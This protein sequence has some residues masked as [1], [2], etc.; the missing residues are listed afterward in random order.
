MKTTKLILNVLLIV[1]IA[2]FSLVGC[3]QL[4]L[5]SIDTPSDLQDRIDSIAAEKSKVD[6]GD[7]TYIDIARLLV[8]EDDNSAGWWTEFTDYFSVPVNKLL[9]LE[10]INHSSGENNWNNWNLVISNDAESRESDDYK[11]Y[12]VLRSDAFGWGGAMA[13]DGYEYDGGIISH[14][15]VEVLGED[16]M[17]D[18]FRETMQGAYVTMEVDH[19]STGNVFVTATAV[20]TNGLTIVQEYNQ[21]VSVSADITAFMVCDGSHFEMKSAYLIPSKVSIIED[22]EPVSIT[23]E[24]APTAIEL[25]NEDFWGNAIATVTFADGSSA[26]VDT[27]DLTFAVIPDLT[28]VG[29]KSVVVSY[30]KTK[31]GNYTQAV[32][33][34]YK[35]EVTNLVVGISA[36]NIN[37]YYSSGDDIHFDPRGII[38]TANYA[39]GSTAILDSKNVVLSYPALVSP[40]VGEQVVEVS[41]EG[42]SE[43]YTTTSTVTLVQGLSQV[44]LNDM[45]T[46]WWS[47]FS[48]DYSVPAGTSKTISMYCY[49][50]ELNGWHSPCTILRGE[51]LNEYAVVRMDNFGWGDGYDQAAVS[52]DWNWDV[53]VENLNGSRVDITVTNNG[54]DT[55]DIHYDVTYANGESHFQTY[56]GIG[57]DSSD[58]NCALVV[59]GAYLVIIE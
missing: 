48:E 26:Q 41:Y 25:G 58:L 3:Q 29:E 28:T 15:Y 17:W 10:F 16:G 43:T 2:A 45:T 12:F 56:E 6:T 57:V 5:Y 52:S 1:V 51:E 13:E 39:D 24:N 35:L 11:E 27:A 20:G 4:E 54:D 14:N 19:S 30:S 36:S 37:Y 8:G 23:F 42:K 50:N 18:K 47:D 49:S 59:E 40:S 33:G 55:A 9:T 38:V 21:P 46:P 34:S 22:E 44:G 32:V 31:Q 53:F 7:T